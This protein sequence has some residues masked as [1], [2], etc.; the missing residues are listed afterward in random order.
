M[1]PKIVPARVVIRVPDPSRLP[2]L[3]HL[4]GLHK[5]ISRPFCL[6]QGN[7]HWQAICNCMV[8]VTEINASGVNENRDGL[9]PENLGKRAANILQ[10]RNFNQ[11]IALQMPPAK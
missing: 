6:D 5:R 10:V 9:A 8:A 4:T 7:S 3:E 2:S 1:R 11:P